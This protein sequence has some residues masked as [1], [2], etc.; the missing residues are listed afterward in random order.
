LFPGSWVAG[1]NEE[2]K[3]F[4]FRYRDLSDKPA[5]LDH[6]GR[7]QQT[8]KIRHCGMVGPVLRG[9]FRIKCMFAM[10]YPVQGQASIKKQPGRRFGDFFLVVGFS[11]RE[12]VQ[13][14]TITSNAPLDTVC[15]Y[16]AV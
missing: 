5:W 15:L 11:G 12:G 14:A 8:M 6:I 7:P 16:R 4:E 1:E 10:D 2:H 9:D 3:K 13:Q